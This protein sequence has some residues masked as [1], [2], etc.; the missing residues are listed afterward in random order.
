MVAL[1]NRKTLL[2]RSL[3]ELNLKF[4]TRRQLEQCGKIDYYVEVFGET[5]AVL[6]FESE[7]RRR[8]SRRRRAKSGDKENV[9]KENRRKS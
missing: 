2:H 8:A 1:E 3:Q 7:Q 9:N 6:R 5:D 4:L